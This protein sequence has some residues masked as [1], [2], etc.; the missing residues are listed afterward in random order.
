MSTKS[1]LNARSVETAKPADK[2]YEIRDTKV[3]GFLLRVQPSGVKSFVVQLGRGKRVTIGKALLWPV[4][5]A[6]RRAVA[7]L[8]HGGPL[9]E[10]AHVPTLREFIDDPYGPYCLE[11]SRGGAA[12]VER[13][14]T[15]FEKE[16]YDRPLTDITTGLVELWRVKRKRAGRKAS[17]INRD[18]AT[19]RAVLS[20]AVDWGHVS[21]DP[22]RGLKLLK[23]DR[24]HVVRY[25][26]EA[27]SK[28]LRKALETAPD[29]LRTMVLISLNTGLRRG[30]LFTLT[31]P[32][33]DLKRRQL[34]VVGS[35]SK[36]GQSRFIPLNQ[37]AINAL[38]TWR[39]S[40]GNTGL[41]FQS[42]A[43]GGAYNNTKR[44]WAALLGRAKIKDFRWHDLRHDFAS[45]LVMSGADLYGVSKLLGHASVVT[46]QRY[47]HLA[48][49]HLADLV[50]RL[51]R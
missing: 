25:L 28:R 7:I 12:T 29:Y 30:E 19:L 20:R 51:D 15:C 11:H 22:L 27:E 46:T 6:R 44:S 48:P 3:S 33:I 37:E 26:S 16:F 18:T 40:N 38:R 17:T 8:A 43:T 10:D 42:A 9:P 14:R 23:V 36:S 1:K 47:A 39:D 21:V 50:A 45:R 35:L 49:D 32:A 5:K 41:V 31:W 13:L 34:S 4:E 2:P 24:A